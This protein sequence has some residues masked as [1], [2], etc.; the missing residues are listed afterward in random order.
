MGLEFINSSFRGLS[1]ALTAH[2][3]PS[4]RSSDQNTSETASTQNQ[5]N[6]TGKPADKT[7]NEPPTLEFLNQYIADAKAE[8]LEFSVDSQSGTHVVK[9][10]DRRT[11]EVIRQFPTEELL[12]IKNTIRSD[13][14]KDDARSGLLIEAEV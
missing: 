6:E 12:K 2:S 7:L 5:A 3:R 13:L 10:V 9:L 8:D 11:S 1:E 14:Q 4:R